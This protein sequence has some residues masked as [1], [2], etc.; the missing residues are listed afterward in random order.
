MVVHYLPKT[1]VNR[2]HV[3]AGAGFPLEQMQYHNTAMPACFA[4]SLY[5][6]V[7]CCCCCCCRSWLARLAGTLSSPEETVSLPDADV[8]FL[9]ALFEQF[10]DP[11]LTLVRS[12]CQEVIATADVNLV[13]SLTKLL[14]VMSPCVVQDSLQGAAAWLAKGR[15]RIASGCSA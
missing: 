1:T 6:S 2:K 12:K 3:D 10:V 13:T 7:A 9:H 8:A 11:G 4:K 14:Q 5:P 15:A